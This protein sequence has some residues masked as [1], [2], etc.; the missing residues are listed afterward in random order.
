MKYLFAAVAALSL[1][2]PAIATTTV[3]DFSS[4]TPGTAFTSATFGDYSVADVPG[5]GSGT[6]IFTTTN[7]SIALGDNLADY[8]GA[9]FIVTRTDGA[10]FD[11]DAVT[12]AET[13]DNGGRV[14][15]DTYDR[16]ETAYYVQS[17]GQQKSSGL[18]NLSHFFVDANTFGA[19][20]AVGL[21]SLTVSG[22]DAGGGAGTVPEPATWAMLVVGFG[23]VGVVRRRRTDGVVAA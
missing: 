13:D 11:V 6:V 18:T 20:G 12:L 14:T 23:L 16:H 15:I 5:Y 1:A 10:N 7:G 4:L 21:S 8:N 22:P 19:D 9:G 17:D 2:A 3:I